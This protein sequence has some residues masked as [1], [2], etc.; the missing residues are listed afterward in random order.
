MSRLS[1]KMGLIRRVG[2]RRVGMAKKRRMGSRPML[3]RQ[4]RLRQPIQWFKRSAY[5]TAGFVVQAGSGTSSGA[6]VA[7]LSQ[8]PN[9]T[10]F[11]NLYDQYCIKGFKVQL[12]PR[13]TNVDNAYDPNAP[14]ITG[15]TTLIGS[16]IDYTDSNNLP[17]YADATQYESFKWTKGTRVHSRYIKPAVSR[18]VFQGVTNGYN[19]SKNVW[20]G[21]DNPSVPHYGIKIIAD[22]TQ[23][24][25]TAE[26]V[27]DIQFT[28]YVGFKNVK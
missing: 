26:V 3:S 5:K 14:S 28:Y 9:F 23:L 2:R 11:T 19:P 1:I 16:V 12:I 27:F 22:N 8:L 20:I 21:T 15:M 7:T 24:T 10:D 18:A 6:F 17:S 4:V 25:G 13:G